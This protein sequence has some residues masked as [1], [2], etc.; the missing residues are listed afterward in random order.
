MLAAVAAP[1]GASV[2]L[3]AEPPAPPAPAAAPAC[4]GVVLDASISAGSIPGGS[5]SVADAC[6][7]A[8]AVYETDVLGY[9]LVGGL[10]AATYTDGHL[11][12]VAFLTARV[13]PDRSL[14]LLGLEDVAAGTVSWAYSDGTYSTANGTRVGGGAANSSTIVGAD[15]PGPVE[16]G[17]LELSI[18]GSGSDLASAR[19]PV[20]DQVREML[21]Q[22]LAAL[23]AG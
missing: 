19:G 7:P 13:S 15:A 11:G 23:A 22:A 6:V 20:A 14:T 21:D 9:R 3:A 18:A 1:A 10:G 5:W 17:Q 16:P 2:P 8:E 4:S 12:R